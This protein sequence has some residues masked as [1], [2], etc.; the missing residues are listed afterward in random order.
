MSSAFQS[1]GVVMCAVLA[2]QKG[3]YFTSQAM[4]FKMSSLRKTEI[5]LVNFILFPSQIH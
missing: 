3:M 2:M 1:F 5:S 4:K